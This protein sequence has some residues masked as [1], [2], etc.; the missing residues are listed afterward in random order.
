ME[1]H[2]KNLPAGS[3]GHMYV[4]GQSGS[5]KSYLIFNILLKEKLRFHYDE[6]FIF[7]CS[8]DSNKHYYDG[9]HLQ[10]KLTHDRR[11]RT[12]YNM[13]QGQF[14]GF[15][16]QNY[17]AFGFRQ[18][19]HTV[20]SFK[21]LPR[22]R[23]DIVVTDLEANHLELDDDEKK[24]TRIFKAY[25]EDKV[26]EIFQRKSQFPNARWLICFDDCTWDDSF[27]KSRALKMLLRNGRAKNLFVWVLSQKSTDLHPKLRSQFSMAIVFYSA[28]QIERSASWQTFGVGKSE[29]DFLRHFYGHFQELPKHSFAF[30][31]LNACNEC[32]KIFWNFEQKAWQLPESTKEQKGKYKFKFSHG[33]TYNS[34]YAEIPNK[35]SSN[36]RPREPT[37]TWVTKRSIE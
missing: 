5:G 11:R 34:K 26:N 6:I 12:V 10:D 36:N 22:E 23:Q 19:K 20:D 14:D 3:N 18:D 7:S 17:D 15:L 1:S 8:Y 37:I 28:N 21:K 16:H 27:T 9:L 35:E 33:N 30:V 4:V 29:N 2:I 24:R 32:E 25:D 31:I 13:G